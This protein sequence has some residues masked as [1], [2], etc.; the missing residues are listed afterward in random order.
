MGHDD[1][2]EADAGSGADEDAMKPI[3]RDVIEEKFMLLGLS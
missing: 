2:A 1:V 3:T